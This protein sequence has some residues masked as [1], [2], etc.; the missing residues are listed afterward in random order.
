MQIQAPSAARFIAGLRAVAF[1]AGMR[2]EFDDQGSC[3]AEPNLR[4]SVRT[5]IRVLVRSTFAAAES[6]EFRAMVK[7]LQ[8]DW[9]RLLPGASFAV[10]DGAGHNIHK[11]QPSRVIKEVLELAEKAVR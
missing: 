8:T 1:N 10:V 2:E 3:L 4:P 7:E 6:E 9:K 11:D 5:P